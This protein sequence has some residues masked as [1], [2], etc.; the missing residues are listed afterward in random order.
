VF[1][2]KADHEKKELELKQ[3]AEKVLL[4][5]KYKVLSENIEAKTKLLAKVNAVP[6][7]AAVNPGPVQNS[8]FDESKNLSC[9][10]SQYYSMLQDK[11]SWE[12]VKLLDEET[13]QAKEISHRVDVS[14]SNLD[15]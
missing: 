6:G 13:I 14:P 9:Q 4:D 7:G 5:A 3:V 10:S 11:Q 8:L 12:F 2:T 1:N 15:C